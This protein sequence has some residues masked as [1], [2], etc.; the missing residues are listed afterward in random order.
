MNRSIDKREERKRKGGRKKGGIWKRKQKSSFLLILMPLELAFR[1][2][3]W[4][5]RGHWS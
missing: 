5:V 4:K 3:G 1:V 2:C